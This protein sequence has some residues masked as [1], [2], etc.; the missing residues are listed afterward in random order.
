MYISQAQR[1]LSL[2]QCLFAAILVDL[3]R[4]NC[5]LFAI[6]LDSSVYWVIIFGRSSASERTWSDCGTLPPKSPTRE[7]AGDDTGKQL[8]ARAWIHADV[9]VSTLLVEVVWFASL[10][11]HVLVQ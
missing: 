2:C 3:L 8:A 6:H 4:F 9:G 7:T 5:R 10:D 1:Q 11:S